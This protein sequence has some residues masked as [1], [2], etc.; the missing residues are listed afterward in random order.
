M[1]VMIPLRLRLASVLSPVVLGAAGLLWSC[2][3]GDE[4]ATADTQGGSGKPPAGGSAGSAGSQAHGGGSGQAPGGASGKGGAGSGGSGEGGAAGDDAEGGAAGDDGEGGAAGDDGEGGAGP[5]GSG[6]TAGT[7]GAA[8]KP[9]TA[10]YE[11]TMTFVTANIGR[12]YKK[13]ATMADALDNIGDFLDKKA[14]P[15]FIGWQEI[16]ESDP[17]GD[18]CE[19]DA[20]VKRFSTKAGWSNYRPNADKEPV[21]S[22]EGGKGATT[23]HTFA[24]AGW[25]GV[26]PT[27]YITVVHYPERNL[28]FINTHFIAGAWTPGW[29]EQAKRRQYWNKAW[30]V[31]KSEVAKEHDKGY[32][33]V[34]TGDLNRPRAKSSTNP[35]WDPTSLHAGTIVVG[36]VSLDYVFAVPAAK[37][38]YVAAGHS[39]VSLNNIQ[40]D[41]DAHWAT[42]AFHVK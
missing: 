17:C 7:G 14:G 9:S 4:T 1:A 16:S 38:K 24:S 26:S 31:L 8:G 41:H 32:N 25:A 18:S 35:A 13:T 5:G 23:R 30:A 6:G 34:A 28:S 12:D 36:G 37:Y 29:K 2:S 42:G 3:G 15:R 20:I 10:A 21:T 27:R 11:V 22:K 40:S 33:V 39:A 19:Y